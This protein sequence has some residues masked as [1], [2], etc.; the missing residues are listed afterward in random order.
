M[1]RREETNVC[2]IIAVVLQRIKDLEEER[3]GPEARNRYV[4]ISSAIDE[5]RALCDRL[6]WSK[7]LSEED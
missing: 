5:L 4:S 3:N 1:E 2:E 7:Y 6:G